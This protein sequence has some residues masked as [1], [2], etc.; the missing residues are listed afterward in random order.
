MPLRSNG[1]ELRRLRELKGMTL[2]EFA[3][4]AGYTLTHV[5]LV[6]LGKNNAGPRYLRAAAHI[7]DCKISEI[8]DGRMPTRRRRD[9]SPV[10]ADTSRDAA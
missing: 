10:T 5:S 3:K 1:V 2:T 4:Q 7:L 9:A 6:E 8:T